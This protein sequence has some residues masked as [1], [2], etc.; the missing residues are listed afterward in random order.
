MIQ[1]WGRGF[2]I[3]VILITTFMRF[4][5]SVFLLSK[6]NFKLL[7]DKFLKHSSVFKTLQYVQVFVLNMS[8]LCNIHKILCFVHR[9]EHFGLVDFD[10][11]FHNLMG[12]SFSENE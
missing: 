11:Y 6:P 10:D 2:S 12:F 3:K 4:R 1:A 5:K 9:L 7:C 8:I